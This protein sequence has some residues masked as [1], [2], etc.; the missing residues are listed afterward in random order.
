MEQFGELA[1]MV[2]ILDVLVPQMVDKLE[3]VPLPDWMRLALGSDAAGRVWTCVWKHST[4]VHWCLEGT[5]SG[6]APEGFTASPARK[7]NTGPLVVDVLVNISDK[8]LQSKEFDLWVRTVPNCAEDRRFA[9]CSS[10]EDVDAPLLCN[11]SVMVQTVQKTVLVPQL[12]FI[13]VGSIRCDH[14]A[15]VPT[16]F[17]TQF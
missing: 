13:D 5:P 2:Q 7:I 8:F 14:T 9:R 10:W 1:P 4:G 11:D 3:D 17:R 16:V 12:Q 15:K 6:P